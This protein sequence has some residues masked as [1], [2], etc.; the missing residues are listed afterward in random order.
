[1]KNP[2]PSVA[3]VMSL[4]DPDPDYL[5]VQLESLFDQDYPVTLFI[6]VDGRGYEQLCSCLDMLKYD[7]DQ[8]CVFVEENIGFTASFLKC[9]SYAEADL[10]AFA[11]QDDYW[12]SHKIASAVNCL[13]GMDQ[14]SVVPA[15]C[16]CDM[17][18]TDATL[19][20]LENQP[21]RAHD[22]TFYNAI[23][24]IPISGVTMVFN[25]SLRKEILK[26]DPKNCQGMI[27]GLISL[28]HLLDLWFTIP[29]KEFIID[30]TKIMSLHFP[31]IKLQ[32]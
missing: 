11:D 20:P 24:E 3:I 8:L 14:K 23:S 5:M 30:V 26:G 6:R 10:F 31:T 27:G 18:F 32:S 25:N 28:P 19:A 22:N 13:S 7:S 16:Y 15:L 12:V 9:L 17:V 29:L 4:Y 21:D 2:R 1:M